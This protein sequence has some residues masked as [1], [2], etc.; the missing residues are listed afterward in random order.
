MS[1]VSELDKRLKED[2]ANAKPEDGRALRASLRTAIGCT[3]RDLGAISANANANSRVK[4]KM[5]KRVANRVW[6]MAVALVAFMWPRRKYVTVAAIYAAYPE[7]GIWFALVVISLQLWVALSAVAGM[8]IAG[9]EKM[10]AIL[11]SIIASLRFVRKALELPFDIPASVVNVAMKKHK[12]TPAEAEAMR[13]A[14]VRD[15]E[16]LL[17][18]LKNTR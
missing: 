14:A 7:I 3:S 2:V 5:L 12:L 18:T 10:Q 1:T 9:L 17:A 11:K 6:S 13:Q 8:T 16:K 15:L 4:R